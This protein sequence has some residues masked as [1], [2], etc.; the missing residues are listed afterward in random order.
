MSATERS[1]SAKMVAS[2]AAGDERVISGQAMDWVGGADELRAE[3]AYLR[4]EFAEL[5]AYV[6]ETAKQEA[7]RQT[8]SVLAFAAMLAACVVVLG[9]LIRT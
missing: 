9:L 5:S 1:D 4:A 2:R 3:F 7:D 8:L 6:A